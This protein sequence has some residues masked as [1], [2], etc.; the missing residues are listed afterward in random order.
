MGNPKLLVFICLMGGLTCW[1]RIETMTTNEADFPLQSFQV[2]RLKDW[3]PSRSRCWIESLNSSWPWWNKYFRKVSQFVCFALNR[4]EV[5]GAPQ[6]LNRKELFGDWLVCSMNSNNAGGCV[7]W[8]AHYLNVIRCPLAA[9]LISI[10]FCWRTF[11][12]S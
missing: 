8:F 12:A 5:T 7:G 2:L 6:Q 4:I 11:I 10:I 1:T 3:N 9:H